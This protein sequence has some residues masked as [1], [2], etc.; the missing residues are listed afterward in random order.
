MCG[1]KRCAKHGGDRACVTPSKHGARF[2]VINL[3]CERKNTTTWYDH[4]CSIGIVP[5]K[6]AKSNFKIYSNDARMR[7][8]LLSIPTTD[9]VEFQI[10]PAKQI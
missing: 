9:S 7:S 4:P 1:L 2:V 5:S 3:F 8:Q 10:Q 6:W